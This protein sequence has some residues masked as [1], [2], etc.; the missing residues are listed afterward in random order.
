MPRDGAVW[1]WAGGLPSLAAGSPTRLC[2]SPCGEYVAQNVGQPSPRPF[3]SR[4][5][6]LAARLQES[7]HQPFCGVN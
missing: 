1:A 5:E 6:G 4:G 2:A 7:L 3:L